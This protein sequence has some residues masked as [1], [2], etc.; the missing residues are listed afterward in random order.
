MNS[1]PTAQR[2]GSEPAHSEPDAYP[3]GRS[4]A[5]TARLILQHQ[6]YGPLTRQFFQAAGIGRGMKVLDLGSGAGDVAML[7]ADLVGPDGHV[8]GVDINAEIL[9]SARAR[10]RAVGWS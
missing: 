3:L 5:E 10:V 1:A 2:P 4:E 9:E 8:I 6:I 7:L